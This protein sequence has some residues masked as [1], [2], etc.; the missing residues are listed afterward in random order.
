MRYTKDQIKTW[1][2]KFKQ[3]G[4][5]VAQFSK[6][7]PFHISTLSYWLRK[8]D[9]AS[10]FIEIKPIEVPSLSPIEIRRPDGVVIS[11][12]NKL[13]IVDILQLMKC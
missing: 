2:T 12:A 5:S 9:H 10:S 11:I 4:Q 3:S 7:K 6:D 13:T 1:V 8:Y